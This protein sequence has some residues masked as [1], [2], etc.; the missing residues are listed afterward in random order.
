M[1]KVSVAVLCERNK[2]IG[3]VFPNFSPHLGIKGC[4]HGDNSGKALRSTEVHKPLYQSAKRHKNY[5]WVK[6][7]INVGSEDWDSRKSPH[8]YVLISLVLIKKIYV[9]R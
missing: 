4:S 2:S 9:C 6:K 7:I 5:L 8:A 3:S 1:S